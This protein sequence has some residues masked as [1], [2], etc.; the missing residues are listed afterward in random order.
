MPQLGSRLTCPRAQRAALPGHGCVLC[1]MRGSNICSFSGLPLRAVGVLGAIAILG[2]LVILAIA[3]DQY[4]QGTAATGFTT[5]IFLVVF[6]SGIQLIAVG[7]LGSFVGRV[8]DE[9]KRRPPFLV[10][11]SMGLE[12]A[13]LEKRPND[14]EDLP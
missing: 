14:V 8:Y 12:D 10:S 1:D 6:L 2:A 9:L 4:I 11:D 5:V 3:I 7:I 13:V